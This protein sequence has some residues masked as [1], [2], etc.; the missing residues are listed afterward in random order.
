M[1]ETTL[2]DAKRALLAQ[3]LRRREESRTITARAPGTT[4]PL[5]HAQERLWFLEQYRPGT[6]TYTVPVAARLRGDLDA[7]ALRR[8]L[9]EIV[10]RHEA[11]RTRFLTTEDGTPE[12]VVDGPRPAELRVTEAADLEAAVELLDAELATPFDLEHGPLFR[13]VLVRL[14]PDDHVLLIAAHHTVIDGW[15]S[16]VIIRELLALHD[17]ATPP[18]APVGYGDYAL[19]QRG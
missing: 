3:R 7:D 6:T 17:G 19:W 2:S 14:A 12:L 18:S 9:D 16:D 1:T 5:S 11:L 13:T 4:P 15:S 10:A 8:A